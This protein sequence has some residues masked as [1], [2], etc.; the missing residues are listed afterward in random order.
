MEKTLAAQGTNRDSGHRSSHASNETMSASTF[1]RTLPKYR[2]ISYVNIFIYIYTGWG[3]SSLAKLVQIT[4]ITIVYDTQITIFR[5]VYKPT[6]NW[7]APSCIYIYVCEDIHHTFLGSP[8]AR[9]VWHEKTLQLRFIFSDQ[10]M[11]FFPVPSLHREL[12][13]RGGREYDPAQGWRNQTL[14]FDLHIFSKFII[15]VIQPPKARSTWLKPAGQI[16]ST[17]E[18]TS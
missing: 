4:I 10:G 5:W 13:C 8:I 18:V 12:P 7:G 1:P 15:F 16:D 11:N 17:F 6:Y 3:P 14:Q 9:C 2:W